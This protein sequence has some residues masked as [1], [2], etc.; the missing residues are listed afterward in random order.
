MEYTV[1]LFSNGYMTSSTTTDWA[2]ATLSREFWEQLYRNEDTHHRLFLRFQANDRTVVIAAGRPCMDANHISEEDYKVYLDPSNIE[3]LGLHGDGEVVQ[4]T[5]FSEE[6]FPEA[7][8]I[9]IRSIDSA[10][11]NSDVKEELEQALTQLGILKLHSQIEVP[12]QALGGYAIELFISQLEP[13]SLVLCHGDDI[14]LEF[15]EAVDAI[16]P[17]VSQRPPT[18]IPE[19]PPMLPEMTPEPQPTQGRVLGSDPT[20]Q[21]PAWRQQLGPPRRRS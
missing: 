19:G 4:V 1:S 16:E 18:P 9:V 11:Y 10:I 12:I 13:A 5:V 6:A 21:A 7:T 2:T 20:I 17:P 8:R 3:R 15:E 14:I